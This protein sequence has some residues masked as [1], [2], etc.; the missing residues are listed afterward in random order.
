M[1]SPW[2][3]T[4]ELLKYLRCSRTVLEKN[5]DQFSYGV[6]WRRVNPKMPQ[7]KILYHLPKVEKIM[8]RPVIP[9]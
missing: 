5:K 6:H 4:V 1:D 9:R 8:C 2:V 7:S 3:T